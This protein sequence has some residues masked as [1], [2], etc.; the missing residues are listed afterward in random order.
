MSEKEFVISLCNKYIEDLDNN[1]NNKNVSYFKDVL[2]QINENSSYMYDFII[3]ISENLI[4]E[5]FKDDDE[6]KKDFMLGF[7]DL[8]SKIMSFNGDNSSIKLTD[9]ENKIIDRFKELIVRYVNSNS[10]DSDTV[11]DFIL[12][13][14]N[15]SC[16]L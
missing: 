13:L 7:N 4:L 5:L 14:N 6:D 12:R 1:D 11:K 3:G 2:H 15:N 10:S 8:K 16:L 9:D